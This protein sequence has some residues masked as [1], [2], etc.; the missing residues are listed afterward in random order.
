[1]PAIEA[2]N[3]YDENWASLNEHDE[4]CIDFNL[5]PNS[6]AVHYVQTPNSSSPFPILDK[7]IFM[8]LFYA[9]GHPGPIGDKHPPTAIN[10]VETIN[11]EELE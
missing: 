1:M 3:N 2:L 4:V 9:F 11:N 10:F 6:K 5:A 8:D 7:F